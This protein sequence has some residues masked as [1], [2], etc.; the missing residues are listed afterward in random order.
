VIQGGDGFGFA[1][2]SITE[3]RG[4]KLDCDHTIQACVARLPHF[5]HAPLADRGKDFVRA[6]LCSGGE[7][8]LRLTL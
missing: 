3:L 8:H 6:E 4:A 2:E 1:P 7:W 5:S